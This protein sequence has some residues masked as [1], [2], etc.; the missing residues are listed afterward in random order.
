MGYSN[1]SANS[2]SLPSLNH[3]MQGP[4][5]ATAGGGRGGAAWEQKTWIPRLPQDQMGP[6]V[7]APVTPST[8]R[9]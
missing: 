7:L 1:S 5:L 9:V 8:E 3:N 4:T 2:P 6:L